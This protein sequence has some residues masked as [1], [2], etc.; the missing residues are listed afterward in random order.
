M[1]FLG[2]Y[3]YL[4]YIKL[5][6]VQLCLFVIILGAI[7]SSLGGMVTFTIFI[8]ILYILAANG[9]GFM[10]DRWLTVFPR[11]VIA[12][13]AGYTLI[14]LAMV[15]ACW[16]S[17]THYFTAWPHNNDTHTVFT[18]KDAASSDTIVR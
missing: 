8:P 17:C 11:N 16:Y 15:T 12:Q 9:I 6:R 7:L 4:R 2:G 10:I 18:L 5:R 1:I 3:L 14:G 13:S